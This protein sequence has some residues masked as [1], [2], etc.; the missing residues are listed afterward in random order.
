MAVGYQAAMVQHIIMPPHIIII[1][2]PPLIMRLQHS[3][4]MALSM[5]SMG[6][7]SHIMPVSVILHVIMPIIIGIGIGIII[8]MA[9]IMFIPPIIGIM[10]FIG[11]IPFIMGFIIGWPMPPIIGVIIGIMF[12][13]V[14]MRVSIG[15]RP[16]FRVS[17]EN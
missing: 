16:L 8:G 1:G 10:P 5:P 9:P 13:A 14:F 6:F 7:I 2:M 17:M 4:N 11:I 12:I 15:L 3:M